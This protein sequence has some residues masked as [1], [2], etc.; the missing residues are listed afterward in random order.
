M[1]KRTWI[2]YAI[3]LVLVFTV[4]VHAAL[5]TAQVSENGGRAIR[6]GISQA[7]VTNGRERDFIQSL[8]IFLREYVLNATT[9]TG[10]T[11]AERLEAAQTIMR[12]IF[13]AQT[14]AT[15]TDGGVGQHRY[16]KHWLTEYVGLTNAQADTFEPSL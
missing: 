1:T 3:Y 13:L 15:A 16:K 12:E 4:N 2:F 7:L 8:A 5:T 9:G 14:G 11:T 6:R 10:F